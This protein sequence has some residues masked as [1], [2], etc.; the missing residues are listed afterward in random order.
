[1][2]TIVQTAPSSV[3][4]YKTLTETTL[5]GTADTL[6]YTKGSGQILILRNPTGSA[7]TGAK[8]VGSSSGSWPSPGSTPQDLS[9]G[10][11]LG[12][13]AAGTSRMVRLDDIFGYLQ[14]TVSITGGTGLAASLVAS[15]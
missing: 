4:L 12:S 14:G 3:T 2:A 8:I 6:T 15:D 11:V 13:I 7:I 9:G 10:F 5:T 1:M